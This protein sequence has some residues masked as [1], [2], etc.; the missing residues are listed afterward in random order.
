MPEQDNNTDVEDHA[1][2]CCASSLPLVL[3]VDEVAEILRVNRNTVYELFH[4]GKLPGGCHVGRNIRFSSKALLEWL[5]G[6]VSA[7]HRKRRQSR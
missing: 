4:R 6:N 1:N 5:R 7:S 2:A 3:T